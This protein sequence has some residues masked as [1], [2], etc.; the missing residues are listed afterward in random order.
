MKSGEFDTALVS[1]N[2]ASLLAASA[3][4]VTIAPPASIDD[5]PIS[6]PTVEDLGQAEE[7]VALIPAPMDGTVV[8]VSAPGDVVAAGESLMVLEAMK[9]EHVVRAS[10]GGTVLAV[11]AKPGE[12]VAEG[13]SCSAFALAR[14]IPAGAPRP[15]RAA[16]RTSAG[17]ARSK[18]SS[19]GV[20]LPAPW[21]VRPSSRG[22]RPRAS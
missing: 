5:A 3:H 11:A 1:K 7:G 15:R 12:I 14:V 19:G 18:R 21:A 2:L 9:M 8:T 22:R 6:E 10:T 4:Q 16:S 13:A 20:S 17:P